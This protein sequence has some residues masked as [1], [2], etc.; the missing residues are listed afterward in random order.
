MLEVATWKRR[1]DN[2]AL[3]IDE[4]R[5]PEHGS[6]IDKWREAHER[7]KKGFPGQPNPDEFTQAHYDAA[8]KFHELQAAYFGSIAAKRPRSA[9]DFGGPGGHDNV[10]PFSE[11][12]AKRH[13]D[14]KNKY[15]D[16]RRAIL[17]SGPLGMMAMQ[18]IVVDNQEIWRLL[19]DLRCACNN[20]T[21]LWKISSAA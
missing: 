20:L 8:L 12:I 21:R 15:R 17:E 9:S 18:A 14:I 6:V 13:L 19:P 4:A 2:A 5:K 16:A 10:D 11:D 1:R 3:T 7:F